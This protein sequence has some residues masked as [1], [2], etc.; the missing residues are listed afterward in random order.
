MALQGRPDGAEEDAEPRR[1]V[2][3][4]AQFLKCLNTACGKT[5]FVKE[6]EK[7]FYCCPSCG[8]HFRV[9][10]RARVD[11][12]LDPGSWVEMFNNLQSLDPLN[13]KGKR[14]YSERLAES[15][16]KTGLKEAVICGEGT[17]E[18]Q[19][20]VFCVMDMYFIG[21]TRGSVVGEKI[22]RAI[23]HATTKRLPIVIVCCSGGA[24]MDEGVLSLMQ[25][26][27]TSAAIER[28]YKAGLPYVSVLTDP[29]L[30]GVSASYAF[31]ADII[32]AEP[33]AMIGFTG[34][35]VIQDTIKVKLPEGFQEAEFLL[36][37][38]QVDK[39]VPRDQ[40]RGTLASIL[41]FW[42]DGNGRSARPQR[43]AEPPASTAPEASANGAAKNSGRRQPVHSKSAKSGK[44][45]KGGPKKT[46]RKK[47]I[48]KGAR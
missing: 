14:P 15:Q 8:H 28:H 18:A 9:G 22:T 21:A 16:K 26:A 42:L 34:A 32:L 37:H 48:K 23:E 40:I 13:F 7:N 1:R 47:G 10:S 35:R 29:T 36:K 4:E 38:G 43:A 46:A 3:T 27:K 5:L 45:A 2:R 12:T 11:M 33:K 31:L 41:N 44:S 25:M 19:L 17:I 39:V 6:I 20:L 24:R 30:A